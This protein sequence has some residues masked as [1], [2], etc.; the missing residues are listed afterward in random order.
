MITIRSF[1]PRD[2]KKLREIH[3][4]HFKEEFEFPDFFKGFYCAYAIEAN[5]EPTVFAGVRP[6]AEAII[7]TDMDAPARDR[8]EALH[9]TME[10]CLFTCGEYHHDQLHAFVQ[11]ETW[12]RQL[13]SVHFRPTRGKGLVFD[14]G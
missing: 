7:V 6:I 13:E 11:D 9:K 5:G 2:I 12:L 14:I 4:K 3:E 1:H 8:V 10:A